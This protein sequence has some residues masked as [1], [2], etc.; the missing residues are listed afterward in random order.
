MI[1]SFM[2]FNFWKEQE[3]FEDV[4]KEI[5]DNGITGNLMWRLLNQH[6]NFSKT[7]RKWS[8]ECNGDFFDVVK[9]KEERN[10]IMVK[11]HMNWIIPIT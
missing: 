2:F 7:L 1:F 5:S 4:V 6:K 3:G 9:Q 10:M 8:K 11:Q